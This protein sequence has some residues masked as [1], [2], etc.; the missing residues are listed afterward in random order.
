[1]QEKGIFE[2]F[3][4]GVTLKYMDFNGRAR[5]REY[6]SYALCAFVIGFVAGLIDGLI[7]LHSILSSIVGLAF[8]LPGLAIGVRRLHDIGKDWKYLLI[9]LIPFGVFYL[10]YL[11][12][13]DSQP[14]DN[15]YGPNPKG[16]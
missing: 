11:F 4:E 12:V 2:Y 14:G 10:I 9:A 1:M 15:A 7:G 3:K 5:R 8:L 16:L 6:W 13:Q